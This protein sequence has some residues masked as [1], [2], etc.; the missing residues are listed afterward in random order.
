MRHIGLLLLRLGLG[1]AMIYGHGYPKLMKIINGNME[2]VD[3]IGIGEAATLILATIT[4][5]VL[6]ILIILG[7][8]TRLASI[9]VAIT[10]AVAFFIFHASDSFGGS[11]EMSF[12]YLIGFVS[13]SLLGPGRYS[14]DRA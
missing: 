8:K 14:I 2:F 5:V 11:K 4:E 6:P 10:M 13:I 7:L 3:P 1:A 12:L 9:P